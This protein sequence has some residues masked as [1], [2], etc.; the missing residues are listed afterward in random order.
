MTQLFF[1]LMK[2]CKWPNPYNVPCVCCHN[3]TPKYFDLKLLDWH[4]Q[5][6][7]RLTHKQY[8]RGICACHSSF[9]MQW[10]TNIEQVKMYFNPNPSH[11]K[12]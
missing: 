12:V 3:D 8:T 6:S 9:Q 11:T 2:S 7:K 10:Q 4:V 5:S 1:C